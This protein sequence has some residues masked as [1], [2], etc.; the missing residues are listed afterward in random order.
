[1]IFAP[2]DDARDQSQRGALCPA[3]G[4]VVL[5]LSQPDDFLGTHHGITLAAIADTIAR[6]KHYRFAG[7][8]TS[9]S[10]TQVTSSSCPTRP[11]WHFWANDDPVKLAQ[12]LK[13][14]LGQT[15]STKP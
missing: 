13:A 11:F 9:P 14:A 5:F 1:L 4:A 10:V 7:R 6:L 2:A 12:G 15:N 3:P 8:W